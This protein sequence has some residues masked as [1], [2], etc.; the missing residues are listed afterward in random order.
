[1]SKTEYRA[2][3]GKNFGDEG[4]GLATDFLCDKAY[5]NLVVRANGGAQSGHTVE[6]KTKRFVFHELSSGSFKNADT[7]WAD[8]YH[9]DL[10][11][12]SEEVNDFK[13]VS[14]FIPR[15]FA[16]KE[17]GI[18]TILDVLLNMAFEKARGDNRHGSCAMGIYETE[19]RE[20]AGLKITVGD[21]P[22]MGVKGLCD[23]LFEIKESYIPKRLKEENIS[24]EIKKKYVDLLNDRNVLINF[25]NE[26]FKNLSLIKIVDNEKSFFNEYDQV[27]F[28]NG[29]GLLLDSECERFYPN[30]SG[31]RTGLTN[32]EKILS[33]NNEKL[34]EVVYVSRA[35]VTRH[36]AG[37][38]P[39]ECGCDEIT[40]LLK[41]NTN[42]P[43]EWQGSLRYA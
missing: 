22:S 15:I 10:Y 11:K 1:M 14:G 35:Y 39:G 13:D 2:V 32:I 4:K 31:S 43:N 41:D 8:T 16:S 42:L 33:R 38:L 6:T 24:I 40:E 26:V 19:L 36:G 12:L 7:Y 30:V 28:E 18:T 27:I 9:P 5:K 37:C 21:L 29:Q 34:S 23:R 3:I 25:S 17:A 20:K